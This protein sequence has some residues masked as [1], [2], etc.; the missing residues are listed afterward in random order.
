MIKTVIFDLDGTF[1]DYTGADARAG[2][3]VEKYALEH[4]G[5]Q[6]EEY[7]RSMKEQ[8][9]L[10][11]LRLGPVAA[12]HNRLVR[13]Q[14]V[15]EKHHLPVYPHTICMAELYWSVF[16][17][18][19]ELFPGAEDLLKALKRAGTRIG[20]GTNM[21]AY[22]Q[23]LKLRKLAIGP[24]MDF[25][26]TSEDAGIEKPEREFFE[27][28]LTKAECLPEECLFVGDSYD[29]DVRAPRECGMHAV[30][31]GGDGILYPDCLKEDGRIVMGDV[32]IGG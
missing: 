20:I 1:Y 18:D 21:T 29:Y 13:M 10:T 3:A 5:M 22:V 30:L 6:P 24:Y 26:V 8:L 25:V 31:Y 32:E 16:L 17:K 2:R 12:T 23:H 9:A 19:I 14:N 4:F 28:C 27:Y 15:L 7:R 11:A